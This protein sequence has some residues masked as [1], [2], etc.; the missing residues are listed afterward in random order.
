MVTLLSAASRGKVAGVSSV[1]HQDAGSQSAHG[2][3]REGSLRGVL[4]SCTM[5]TASPALQSWGAL[6]PSTGCGDEEKRSEKV[7]QN[8]PSAQLRTLLSGV[9]TSWMMGLML[10]GGRKG[11]CSQVPLLSALVGTKN[12]KG[13]FLLPK[14]FA[15]Q[16]SALPSALM[17]MSHLREDYGPFGML[18]L[19]C[20]HLW[21]ES[22][23]ERQ[24]PPWGECNDLCGPRP[25]SQTARPHRHWGV[26]WMLPISSGSRGGRTSHCP[27][28][29]APRAAAQGDSL[30]L[31]D[32]HQCESR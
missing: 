8:V 29:A 20:T 7:P 23:T 22:E 11:N 9:I 14:A 13:L 27:H 18:Q 3:R 32:T 1:T 31:Y 15:A 24:P 4:P 5:L 16:G 28:D 30:K 21:N 6:S 25:P 12:W 17:Q 10:R 26:P 2:V 19:H